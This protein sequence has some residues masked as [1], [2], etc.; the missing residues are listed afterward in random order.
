[1]NSSS[2]YGNITDNNR[3]T[4]SSRTPSSRTVLNARL[5]DRLGFSNLPQEEE[6]EEEEEE[7]APSSPPRTRLYDPN[8]P[9]DDFDR[10]FYLSEEGGN[11]MA[12]DSGSHRFLGNEQTFKEREEQMANSRNKGT[13]KIAGMSA[14]ASQLHVD[15][16]A[17]EENRLLQSGVASLREAQLDFDNEEDN[18]VTLIVHNI[19]PPFLDGRVNFSMQQSTVSVVKDAASDMALNS[20][21][22]SALLRE[23]REKKDMMKM[24]KRFWEIGGSKMGDVLGVPAPADESSE[25]FAATTVGGTTAQHDEKGDEEVDY[26]KDSAFSKH[27]KKPKESQSDFAKNKSMR[28][29]REFLPVFSV[30]RRL[31]EVIRENQVLIVVGETGSGKVRYSSC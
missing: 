14:K 9:D 21:K 15:Q 20:R 12:M 22:G 27:I 8:E 5:L 1:M 13:T 17:W 24:R 3:S 11:A 30:R 7:A 28:E 29:Q 25:Q 18:R 4:S 2:S 26:R 19:K 23:V 31:L 16:E 6:R 10:G